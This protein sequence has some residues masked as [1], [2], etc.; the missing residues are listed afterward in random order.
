[1]I[2]SLDTAMVLLSWAKYSSILEA[3]Y[4][5]LKPKKTDYSNSNYIYVTNEFGVNKVKINTFR[6]HLIFIIKIRVYVT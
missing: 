5:T 3:G 6:Y 1:M 4:T 2:T